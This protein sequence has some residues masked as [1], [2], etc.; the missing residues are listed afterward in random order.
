MSSLTIKDEVFKLLEENPYLSAKMLAKLLELSYQKY[1]FYL[2]N[3]RSKWRARVRFEHGSKCSSHAW[4]GWTLMP[5]KIVADE[6]L[7]VSLRIAALEM[8]WEETRSRNKWLLFRENIGRLQWF[9]TGR[10]NIYVRKPANYGRASQLLANG[11]YVLIND[12]NQF[13]VMRKEIRFKGAHYVFDA[14]QRLPK[15]AIDVF[16][17]SSGV[18]I[19]L[20]DRTHPHAVEVLVHYPDWAERN[21][22]LISQNLRAFELNTKAFEQVTQTLKSIMDFGEEIKKRGNR[23]RDF[24]T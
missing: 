16:D 18:T 23:T 14:G 2:W 13:E 19:K 8:G 24:I 4:R 3:L 10:I 6:A 20:G 1:K 22:K 21:E 5:S 17:K 15:M 9:K 12:V 11:L 7:H